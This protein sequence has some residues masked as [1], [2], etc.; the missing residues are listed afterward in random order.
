MTRSD[1]DRRI[2]A[3]FDRVAPRYDVLNRILSAGRD[4]AWRRRA[5]SLARLGPEEIALDV[6]VGSG[7]LAFDL[8]DVSAP[9]AR[10]VGVDLSSAMLD[11]VVH[12]ADVRAERRFSG[13]LANGEHLPF[14][15]ATFD[16]VVAG[17]TVRNFGDLAAGLRDLRRVLRGGGRAVIL[18]LATPADRVVRATYGVYFERITP[19]IALMLGGDPEAYRY[20]PRSVAAFPDADR[21]AA[22]MADAGFA[23][24]RYERLSLGIAAIHTGEA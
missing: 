9:T 14:A 20:L 6:G 7:D 18:E 4:I 11:L 12:R 8:L 22:L 1:H 3:M 10:V 23:R 5:A 13:L 19:L 15:D 24:V 21:L 2:A 16:R 17:F